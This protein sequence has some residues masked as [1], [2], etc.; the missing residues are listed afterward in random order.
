VNKIVFIE[1]G[2]LRGVYAERSEYIYT[3]YYHQL[4][5]QFAEKTV[6]EG[7]TNKRMTALFVHSFMDG[8]LPYTKSMT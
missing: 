3:T 6:H 7:A 1:R 5:W 4:R 8:L 2:W